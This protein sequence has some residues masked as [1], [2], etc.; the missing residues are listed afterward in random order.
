MNKTKY[1][2][3]IKR[4]IEL[5]Q[6]NELS[7]RAKE[8][9]RE[10]W[11]PAF[12]DM[13]FGRSDIAPWICTSVDLLSLDEQEKIGRLPLLSIGQMIEFLGEDWHDFVIKSVE[14]YGDIQNPYKPEELCDALWEAVKKVLEGKND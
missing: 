13:W 11:K 12:G 2:R 5:K 7:E 9:L 6:L 3:S 14:D 1:S 10:W 4:H 8:R